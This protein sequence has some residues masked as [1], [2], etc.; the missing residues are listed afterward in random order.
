MEI[1]IILALIFYAFIAYL[2]LDVAVFLLIALLPSY[3]VRFDVLGIPATFLEAMILISFAF[4]FVKT[5]RLKVHSWFKQRKKRMPYPFAIE[6]SLILLIA[7]IAAGIFGINTAA[8]G[9][10]KAYFFEPIAL[11]IVIMNVLPGKKGRETIVLGLLIGALGTAAFAI[12]QQFTGSFI[13]NNFWASIETRRVV[14]WFGYPNAVGLYLA[15]IVMVLS[16]YLR[17]ISKKKEVNYLKITLVSITIIASVLAIYFAKSEGALI[18]LLAA[19]AL[20]IFFG[21]KHGKA[22]VPIAFVILI[23]IIVVTPQLRTYTIDKLSL[24]DLSGEIRKQQ[25]R[26]TFQT[27][28][29]PAFILGNGLAGYPDAVAPYHQEGI[30]FN[31]DRIDNFHSVLYG[32]GELREKYWQPVEIYLYPHNIFLN[33]WTELGLLGMLVFTWLIIKYLYKSLRIYLQRNNYLSLGL[34]AAMI[35]ILVHGL[36][37]VP[38]FKNDLSAL[39]F[40]LLALLA[41][42]MVESKLAEKNNK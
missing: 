34:F 26:E 39:F 36:V 17:A 14:S 33:F 23:G 15:P 41:S 21:F 29:G 30:F 31:R 1:S 28:K 11:Y 5:T 27:L 32:S 13:S 25:W 4:W 19:S 38:Y 8:L 3:L 24:N 40:I 9:V 20:F 12:F 22:I 37:D 16:G 18:A 10:L 2:R 35:T 42:I 6:I 7:F